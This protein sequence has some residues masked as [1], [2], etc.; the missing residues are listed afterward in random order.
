MKSIFHVIYTFVEL[1]LHLIDIEKLKWI[2][3]V[4]PNKQAWIM[5]I[6]INQKIKKLL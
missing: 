5:Q 2:R 6:Q 1:T 3:S 4:F